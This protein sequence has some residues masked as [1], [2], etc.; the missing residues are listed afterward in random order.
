MTNEIALTIICVL[1]ALGLGFFIPVI[2]ELRRTLSRATSLLD[3]TEGQLNSTLAEVD[4]TLKSVRKIT[5]DIN[6]VTGDVTDVSTAVSHVAKDFREISH[7]LKKASH[8]TA[9]SMGALKA[10]LNAAAGVFLSN[11]KF[12][13]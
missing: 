1:A 13:K 8:K 11:I 2:L 5:D 12:K 7:S 10:G 3:K 6:S 4:L 9:G